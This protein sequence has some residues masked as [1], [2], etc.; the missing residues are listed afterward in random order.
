VDEAVIDALYAASQA[1]VRI[2][3]VV[4]GMCA[5]RPGV[6]G[7]SET[8]RVRSVLGRFLEHSRIFAFGDEPPT[9][10]TG[11]GSTEPPEVWIGSAD[12][13]HRNLDRRVEALV[14]LADPAHRRELAAQI[15]TVF[16][17][18]AACWELGPLGEWTRRV[19]PDGRPLRDVQES[20]IEARN[21]LLAA[22]RARMG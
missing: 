20:L 2:D 17:D 16:E 22:R 6:P 21:Q 11:R 12:M 9:T 14:L 3:V 7:L 4:R 10:P 19:S 5:L 15:D 18:D 8:I 13:M 1:G